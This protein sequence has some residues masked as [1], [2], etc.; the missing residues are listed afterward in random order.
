MQE[1]NFFVWPQPHTS[2]TGYHSRI[3]VL[4]SAPSEAK[5]FLEQISIWKGY[6]KS[7]VYKIHGKLIAY[8]ISDNKCSSVKKALGILGLKEIKDHKQIKEIF[9]NSDTR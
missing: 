9:Q 1:N 7:M 6:D 8:E 3:W 4:F 5:D 2:P